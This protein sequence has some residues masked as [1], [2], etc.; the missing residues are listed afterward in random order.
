MAIGFQRGHRRKSTQKRLSL[1]GHWRWRECVFAALDDHQ[2]VNV[3]AD[4]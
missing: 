1:S 2:L 3:V 4:G